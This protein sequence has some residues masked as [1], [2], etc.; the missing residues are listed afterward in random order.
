MWAA[1]IQRDVSIL[2]YFSGFHKLKLA[3][4]N[5][6]S[7]VKNPGSL[8]MILL[9]ARRDL[10]IGNYHHPFWES[11][12]TN[13]CQEFTSRCL[14]LLM[15]MHPWNHI[16]SG[17]VTNWWC[18]HERQRVQQQMYLGM[19]CRL[20]GHC[21]EKGYPCRS[22][23]WG[24]DP[25]PSEC[26]QHDLAHA[27]NAGTVSYLFDTWIMQYDKA[28][29]NS[30]H[31][32][33]IS[34]KIMVPT[35]TFYPHAFPPSSTIPKLRDALNRMFLTMESSGRYLWLGL[36]NGYWIT[37]P[38]CMFWKS[39]FFTSEPKDRTTSRSDLLPWDDVLT[40]S[41]VPDISIPEAGTHRFWESGKNWWVF[42]CPAGTTWCFGY[43]GRKSMQLGITKIK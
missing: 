2:P 26:Q 38:M 41:S 37:N 9:C 8:I 15:S 16:W 3:L 21:G 35:F 40:D 32:I 42:Y 36:A 18:L 43:L 34:T 39:D 14:T 25:I 28:L 23:C 12:V 7:S 20:L 5:N 19:A 13:Q 22:I 10:H 31:G 30:F 17:M 24:L 1:L 11:P 29:P 27:W 6:V 33:S 4:E